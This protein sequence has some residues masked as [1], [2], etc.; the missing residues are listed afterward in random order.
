MLYDFITCT[1]MGPYS[2][3]KRPTKF[4]RKWALAADRQGL[5]EGVETSKSEWHFLR[6]LL[7]LAFLELLVLT[8]TIFQDFNK[9]FLVFFCEEPFYIK[10]ILIFCYLKN[11]VNSFF[12]NIKFEKISIFHLFIYYIPL[13]ALS[14]FYNIIFISWKL[15]SLFHMYFFFC[16][17]KDYNSYKNKRYF[18][19]K[20]YFLLIIILKSFQLGK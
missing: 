8:A 2:R 5:P 18:G 11:G 16:C 7:R 13:F 15:N 9:N 1:E 19:Q 14:F 6:L 3:V 4:N 20:N 17:F 12:S 10:Q